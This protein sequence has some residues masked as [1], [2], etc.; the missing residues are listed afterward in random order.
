MVSFHGFCSKPGSVSRGILSMMV[1][2]WV[3]SKA[4]VGWRYEKFNKPK[5]TRQALID[6]FQSGS[7]AKYK[8][9]LLSCSTDQDS[10]AGM[11]PV[12]GQAYAPTT[13]SMGM[14][15]VKTFLTEKGQ[16]KHCKFC[17]MQEDELVSFKNCPCNEAYYCGKE[18]QTKH[19]KGGHKSVCAW[20]Y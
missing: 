1:K 4:R 12:P 20:N 2:W 15:A 16:L 11:Q 5:N 7:N 19:W 3:S 14:Q 18:Y 10:F 17:Q 6:M 13:V 8:E 9:V